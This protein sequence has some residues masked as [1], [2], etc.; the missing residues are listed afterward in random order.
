MYAENAPPQVGLVEVGLT[1]QAGIGQLHQVK[2][3][4]ALQLLHRCRQQARNGRVGKTDDT[5]GIYHQDALGSILQDRCVECPR[6]F[7]L[8]AQTLQHAPVALLFEQGLNLGLEDLRVERL[9]HVVDGAAG[10]AFEYG[11]FGLFVGG[12]EDN[13]GQPGA[14]AATH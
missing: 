11:G 4:S 1:P 12:E 8:S 3:V 13:R 5:L 2:Q 9:E 10:V 6:G 14:L 7:Q